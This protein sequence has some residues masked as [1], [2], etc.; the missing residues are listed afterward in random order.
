MSCSPVVPHCGG[1][2][3]A[4][5]RF[6]LSGKVSLLLALSLA[7]SLAAQQ[8]PQQQVAA[9]ALDIE[10]NKPAAKVSPTLYGL[11][12]EEINYSYD[13][14]LYAELV[15]NRTFHDSNWDLPAWSL[16]QQG[17]AVAHM[18]L[19]K[20]TGPGAALPLSLRINIET[21]DAA[22]Q[23]GIQ[24]A[25][26][27]GFPI[28]AR[29]AY[30]A[31]FYAKAGN[32]SMGP[33]TLALRD[34]NTGED[35][36]TG[37][38]RSLSTGWQR[39]E[40]TLNTGDVQ[41]SAA[42]HLVLTV[43]HPGTLWIDLLSLFPPTYSNRPNG[44]RIDLMEKLAAMKPKFLRFPGGNYLEGDH[45]SER[46]QWKK[47]IGP[48]VD[49]PTHPSPWHYHS[50][51]GMGLL[52]FLEWCEDLHMQPVLA[53][54]AGYSMAQEHVDP[55]PSLEPYVRDALE[56]IEYVT[57]DTSTPWGAA[58]AKDGH[59]EA[60]H[61][62]FVEIGNEDWFD[63]SGSYNGRYAQFYTAIKKKYPQL[64]LIATAPVN[65]VKPD[66]ID[67]HY[68]KRP[69]EFF[70]DTHHYDKTDRNG[71]KIFV[72]EWATREGVPTPDFGAALGD[73]AWMTGMERNS[74]VVI[75]ASYAPLFVNVNPGGLQWDTDLIGYNTLTSYGSPSYYAQVLFSSHLGDE[76]VQSNLSGGGPRM[77]YSVTRNTANGLVFL[78]L[79]N[80][81]SVPQT[82]DITLSGGDAVQSKAKLFSLSA[83]TVA[84]TNTI[85]EPQ[86]IVP[87]ETALTDVATK[88]RHTLPPYSIHVLEFEMK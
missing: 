15:R 83:K 77:F 12:T 22:N 28:R 86:R 52:E 75:M 85:S 1:I 84:E 32:Q 51:D 30:R 43:Q 74:D 14:G 63:R 25:G 66:V 55:G 80:A 10:V 33:V 62:T 48:L 44:N 8:P 4:M 13:G 64:Q 53:V 49:R 87:V 35:V 56:E 9:A 82:I 79:V 47:T 36:A 6:A 18:E 67:D 20:S 5:L 65:T 39:Y 59:P 26:F 23:A 46:Y 19:D 40:V 7:A 58:R 34:D 29:T 88:F 60:F 42:N 27:W 21:A 16:V 70:D 45:I 41:L 81:D 61:L 24:N 3:Q 50:S 31:S 54:Y 72:G 37:L 2:F 11:M 69:E 73:A 57:G 71:P 17:I 76:V 68:Y 38:V 78:K